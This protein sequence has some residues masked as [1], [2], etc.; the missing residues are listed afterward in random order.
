[1]TRRPRPVPYPPPDLPVYRNYVM[2]DGT[3][4]VYV[5]PDF[6]HRYRRMLMNTSLAP[7]WRSDPTYNLRRK[8]ATL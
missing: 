4:R 8:R 7:N 1:M 6:E 5:D 3:R 2:S